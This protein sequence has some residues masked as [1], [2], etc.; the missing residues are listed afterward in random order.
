[1]ICKIVQNHDLMRKAM[2]TRDQFSVKR[3]EKH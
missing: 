3:E 1:M 2:H